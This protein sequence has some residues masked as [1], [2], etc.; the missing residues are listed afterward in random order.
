MEDVLF[1]SETERDRAAIADYLSTVAESLRAGE[2]ITLRAGGN[3]LD[4]SVPDRATFEV[5][6]EREGDEL[7]VEFEIEWHESD[8]DSGD[9]R[10]E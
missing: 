1:E 8:G 7:S 4:L 10:I 6:A 5:K 3:D 2:S 9:L